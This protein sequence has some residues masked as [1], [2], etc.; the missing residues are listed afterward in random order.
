MSISETQANNIKVTTRLKSQDP[1]WH[2]IRQD[3]ITASVAGDIIRR[4]KDPEP[5][6]DRLKKT[7]KIVTSAMRHGLECEETAALAYVQGMDE[8]VNIY[9]CGLVIS[10]WSPWIA[11][12]PDRKVFCPSLNPPHGLLEIKCPVNPLADCVYL[13]R[14]ENGYHLKDT[15]K[16]YYQMMTQ[17]AVTGLEWCHFFVWTPDESH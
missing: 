5:L 1:K 14:D 3:R 12:T 2:K 10:P 9:P 13:K 7:R 16:Y 17:M 4:R 11:A 8:E 15:H 6:V